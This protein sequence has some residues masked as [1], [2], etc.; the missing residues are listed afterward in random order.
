M[1]VFRDLTGRRFGKLI[2][3]NNHKIS[4]CGRRAWLCVCEC[5]NKRFIVS[6]YLLDGDVNSC[7]CLRKESSGIAAR[8]NV[9]RNYRSNAKKRGIDFNLSIDDFMLLSQKPCFY[10]GVAPSNFSKSRWGNGDFLYNGIDRVDNALGYNVDNCVTCCKSCNIS[11]NNRSQ[12]EFIE[13]I[14]RAYKHLL[15]AKGNVL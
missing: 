2:V 3:T 7:G 15:K 13:W 9:Y 6:K 11:K 5:G 1:P 10:C 4:S 8:N 14:D 12:L